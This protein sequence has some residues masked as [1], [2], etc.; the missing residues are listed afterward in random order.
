MNHESAGKSDARKDN[1]PVWSIEN[2]WKKNHRFKEFDNFFPIHLAYKPKGLEELIYNL[3]NKYFLKKYQSLHIKKYQK[4]FKKYHPIENTTD[5]ILRNLSYYKKEKKFQFIAS[6]FKFIIYEIYF[7]IKYNHDTAFR[8][9]SLKDLNLLK[10][11]DKKN[12]LDK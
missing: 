11:Y 4:I 8:F 1:V 9:Y 3:K 2:I 6:L 10:I 12:H 5:I 7:F